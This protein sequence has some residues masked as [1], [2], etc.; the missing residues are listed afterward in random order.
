MED[1]NKDE[2]ELF[3]PKTKHKGLKIFIGILLIGGL[4]TGG[5]FLYQYK[6]NNPKTIVDNLLADAKEN[7][8]K[9]LVNDV[10]NDLYKIDGHI[11][12]DAN[13]N[14]NTDETINILKDVEV[15]FNGEV[16]PTNSI[17]NLNINTKY[18]ND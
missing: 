17:G 3:I 16:D 5:Y 8:K 7:V 4:I 6:F 1:K 2:E 14:N 15:Q 10:E 12:I 11:K 13:I 9:N 18:K